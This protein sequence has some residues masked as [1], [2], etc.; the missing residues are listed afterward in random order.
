MTEVI[1]PCPMPMPCEEVLTPV[2]AEYPT[3]W[4]KVQ[5]VMELVEEYADLCSNAEVATFDGYEVDPTGI[6]SAREAVV[7]ALTLILKAQ[8]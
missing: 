4:R 6:N 5:E 2:M 1:E 8:K 7:C 3:T